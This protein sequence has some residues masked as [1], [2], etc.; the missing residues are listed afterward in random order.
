MTPGIAADIPNPLLKKRPNIPGA[1]T[2]SL[3]V[4]RAR[5]GEPSGT[6]NP[7]RAAGRAADF[8]FAKLAAAF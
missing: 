6:A 7:D 1:R 2:F 5:D 8:L 4:L 3:C